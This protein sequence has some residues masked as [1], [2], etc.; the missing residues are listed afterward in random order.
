MKAFSKS[1]TALAVATATLGSLPA[2]A[3]VVTFGGQ[4]AT[5]GSGLTSAF[6]PANNVLNSANGYF[7]ETFDLATT[8][9]GLPAGTTAANPESGIS[10]QQGQDCSINSFNSVDI[11]ATGG[12]FSV[13]KGSVSGVAAAPAGNNTCFG[14]GPQQGGTLP[15]TVKIDYTSFLTG[16]IDGGSVPA[17]TA[18]SYL[19]LYYGSIDTYNNIAFYNGDTL[20]SGTG[21]LEDGIIDGSEILASQGG[22]SGNQTAPGSN[23]Y[24]NLFFAPGET[25]TAF[26]FRTTGIAFELDNVVVG[27][28]SR[29]V[30]EPSSIALLG[31]G[32][33][34]FAA[35]RRRK[36]AK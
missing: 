11:S 32:L 27:L 20:L 21:I 9:A 34:G 25:F 22:T 18:I 33:L 4:S 16:L 3:V 10:I 24:V 26:E 36:S 7:I 13:R 8:M 19:G 31:L 23:V 35:I 17:G 30:P 28:T 5:D 6:V 15:A 14:F 2:H 1:L 29:T 12:G